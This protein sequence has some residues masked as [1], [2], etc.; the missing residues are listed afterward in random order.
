MPEGNTVWLA[1]RTLRRALAGSTL[2]GSDI[3]VPAYATTDLT[4]RRVLDV[5]P[6][7]KHILV[8]LDGGLTLHTHLRMDGA[9]RVYPAGRR[10]TDSRDDVRVVLETEKS[11]AVGYRVHDISIVATAEED[12]LV[13]HLGPDLLGPDWD[14]AEAVRRMG[15]DPARAIGE[16]ILDQR[17]L[18]GAGNIYKT[19]SCF[20]RGVSPW[21]PVGEVTDLDA[22]VD[23]LHRLLLANRERY[24]HVTTGDSRPGYRTWVYDRAGRP[25]RRCGTTIRGAWQGKPPY[26]RISYWCPRCQ[27]GPAPPAAQPAQGAGSRPAR[28]RSR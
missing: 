6:R 13:G 10:V 5:Q 19:E 7:G 11:V 26:R 21:L 20:L 8:R 23:L 22:F 4:G 18:A 17:N 1:A 25:C 2:T 28:S 27:P 14:H 24:N 12:S 3:R 9:W 15:S 16:A